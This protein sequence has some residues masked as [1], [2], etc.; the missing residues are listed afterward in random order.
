MEGCTLLI[1]FPTSGLVGAEAFDH[2]RLFEFGNVFSYAVLTHAELLSQ[3]RRRDHGIFL[4]G[5]Y[6]FQLRC[7]EFSRNFTLNFLLLFR[8]NLC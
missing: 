4:H 5:I 3:L 6:D 8:G 2:S 1:N 7:T